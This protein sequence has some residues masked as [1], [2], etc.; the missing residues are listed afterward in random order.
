[1]PLAVLDEGA[2]GSAMMSG[3]FEPKKGYFLKTEIDHN[4]KCF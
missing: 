3:L 4:I 2:W 1:M